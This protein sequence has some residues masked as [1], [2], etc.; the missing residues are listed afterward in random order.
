MIRIGNKINVNGRVTAKK[1]ILSRDN[2]LYFDLVIS[3]T[4]AFVDNG[5]V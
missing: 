1:V 3:N 2:F 5:E 4:V